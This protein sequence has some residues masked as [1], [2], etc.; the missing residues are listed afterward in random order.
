MNDEYYMKLALDLARRGRGY[1][2]PNPMVGAVIVKNGRMIGK[3]YHQRFGGNHAEIN[4]IEN[5]GGNVQGSTLYVTLEPCCHEGK[6]PPCIN[7]I[8]EHKFSRVVIGSIDSNPL[9][10]S[11]G[12]NSLQNRGVEVKTGVLETD[13][14]R[15]NEVFFHFMETGMP[16]ITIKYAQ[17][18]DG[19]IATVTG[20][21]QWISSEASLKFTHR[22]R[23]EHDAILVGRGTVDKDNPEL[24][25]RL[26]RGRNPL[27]VIIDSGLNILEK[28]KIFQNTSLAPTLIATVKTSKDP[29][30][31]KLAGCGA[32]I[33]TVGAD[34]KGKVDLKKLFKIL[35]K[36]NISSVLVEGGAQ[37]IT[38]VLKKNLANRLITVVAP[39]IIGKGIEAVGE[40][41]IRNLKDAKK[42]SFQKIIKR[43]DDIIIDSRLI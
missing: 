5:A 9:V 31:K 38:S 16:F 2:S 25:V 33:I 1:V 12:I 28:A 7:A 3:G 37:I 32:D 6:T 39:K 10:C 26:F 15:L 30:F 17:T 21:S 27:R 11:Q 34:E 23:A 43:G 4:A 14:R 41:N 19:R 35:G 22:L 24:T 29:R 20:N 40:L 42:L 8:I 18:L 13:C 36:R